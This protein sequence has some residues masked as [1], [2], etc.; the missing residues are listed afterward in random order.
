MKWEQ[1]FD[2]AVCRSRL[3]QHVSRRRNNSQRAQG[4]RQ[5][6]A[7]RVTPLAANEDVYLPLGWQWQNVVT[8]I[9]LFSFFFYRRFCICNLAVK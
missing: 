6:Q 4:G 5:T 8:C 3:K 1:E 7:H 2:L 9:L